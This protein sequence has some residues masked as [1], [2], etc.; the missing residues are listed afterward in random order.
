MSIEPSM[1]IYLP[2][3]FIISI[4]YLVDTKD[5][6]KVNLSKIP[7][8]FDEDQLKKYT[9]TQQIESFRFIEWNHFSEDTL[10]FPIDKVVA[11]KIKN[12]SAIS[13]IL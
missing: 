13:R 12:L 9:L 7:F 1:F 2:S 11:K 10:T 4:Y 6:I 8:E 3:K 5:P